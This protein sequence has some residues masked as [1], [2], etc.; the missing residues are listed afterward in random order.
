[1]VYRFNGAAYN[2]VHQGLAIAL[3]WFRPEN[4]VMFFFPK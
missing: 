2:V 4:G 1:M 3:A